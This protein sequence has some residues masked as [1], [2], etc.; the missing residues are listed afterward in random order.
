MYSIYFLFTTLTTLHVFNI[1][2]AYHTFQWYHTYHTYE[3]YQLWPYLPYLSYLSCIPHI[4]YV[5]KIITT[6]PIHTLPNI[7]AIHTIPTLHS[8]HSI[9]IIV[10]KHTIQTIHTVISNIP[11]PTGLHTMPTIHTVSH[12]HHTTGGGWGQYHTFMT[13]QGADSTTPPAHQG[14]STTPPTPQGG[15]GGGQ[16]YGWPMTMARGRGGL[17]RW[18]IYMYT[19]THTYIYIYTHVL[20]ID[21]CVCMHVFYHINL[22]FLLFTWKMFITAFKCLWMFTNYGIGLRLLDVIGWLPCTYY[23]LLD[24]YMHDCPFEWHLSIK[25]R[26]SLICWDITKQD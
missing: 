8:K 2:R 11:Y 25:Y 18:T 24:I 26:W 15:R 10:T 13:P 22:T 12:P 4:P 16:Y 6:P 19:H 5:W 1:Y 7:H 21:V 3:T 17:E 9:P 20:Y 14:D 23:M